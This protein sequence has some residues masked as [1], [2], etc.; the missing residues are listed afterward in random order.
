ML[1]Y[2]PTVIKLVRQLGKPSL[3][4]KVSD[5]LLT[6][7]KLNLTDFTDPVL[8]WRRRAISTESS[9]PIFDEIIETGRPN[10]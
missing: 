9:A 2:V 4:V 6:C 7:V 8:A 1:H 10:A 3:S 5:Y